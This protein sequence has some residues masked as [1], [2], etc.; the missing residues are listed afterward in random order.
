MRNESDAN[1]YIPY[2]NVLAI[3]TILSLINMEE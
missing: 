1:T 3:Y 2:Y